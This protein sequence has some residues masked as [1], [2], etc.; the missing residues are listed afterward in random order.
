MSGERDDRYVSCPYF[1]SNN[2]EIQRKKG[3]IRCE[4]ISKGN[5]ISLTFG[6]ESERM[7]YKRT[8]C[9][10]IEKCHSCLIH[11]MLDRKYEAKDNV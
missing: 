5:T 6:S 10:S 8:F 9:Y 11:Q 3:Q 1:L 4:G 7:R 2:N